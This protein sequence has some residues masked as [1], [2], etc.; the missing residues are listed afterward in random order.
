MYRFNL[1]KK[2]FENSWTFAV[3][4]CDGCEIIVLTLRAKFVCTWTVYQF[5]KVMKTCYIFSS[6]MVKWLNVENPINNIDICITKS[7]QNRSSK[8]GW[9]FI[10]GPPKRKISGRPIMDALY[11]L[12]KFLHSLRGLPRH[13]YSKMYYLANIII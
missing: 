13:K 4:L 7:V 2:L 9:M 10:L 5:N 6:D 12:Y 8:M 1:W 11:N 3:H